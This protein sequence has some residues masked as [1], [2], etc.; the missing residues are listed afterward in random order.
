MMTENSS[1]TDKLVDLIKNNEGDNWSIYAVG[2]LQEMLNWFE[3]IDPKVS[4]NV[5]MHLEAKL[6]K[7]LENGG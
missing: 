2:Y 1:Y 4:E 5:K 6:L 3:M 7:I